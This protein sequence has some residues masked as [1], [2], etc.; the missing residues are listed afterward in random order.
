MGHIKRKQALI[1]GLCLALIAAA[2]VGL[3]LTRPSAPPPSRFRASRG[4]WARLRTLVD[5]KTLETARA[6]AAQAWTRDEHPLAR[7]ALS[8]ADDAV[9]LAF[10]T[11]L[12]DA[13]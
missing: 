11:A 6:L 13:A 12:R 3:V 2:V 7:R 10:A 1:A 9:D 4:P 5:Q 8:V